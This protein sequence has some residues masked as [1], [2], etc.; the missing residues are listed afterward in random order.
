MAARGQN[1]APARSPRA[2]SCGSAN[3]DLAGK[4]RPCGSPW[5]RDPARRTRP[6]YRCRFPAAG[7]L[8]GRAACRR[9]TG[10]G[11]ARS[12]VAR[13]RSSYI[14]SAVELISIAPL[15]N[16]PLQHVVNQLLDDVQ[17]RLADCRRRW[18]TTRRTTCLANQWAVVEA[19][20]TELR[21][22][23]TPDA[24]QIADASYDPGTEQLHVTFRDGATAGVSTRP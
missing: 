22:E 19:G 16:V 2:G 10:S 6:G 7:R 24:K 21:S 9:R 11:E 1:P 4:L 18:W 20:K 3:L 14:S 15:K 12:W 17:A 23:R 13:V 8:G 5:P